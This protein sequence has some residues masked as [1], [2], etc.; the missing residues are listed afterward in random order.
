MFLYNTTFRIKNLYLIHNLLH[1]RKNES[2]RNYCNCSL[3]TKSLGS[4]QI[5][6]YLIQGYDFQCGSHIIVQKMQRKLCLDCFWHF[7]L[8]N[9]VLI[10]FTQNLL[11]YRAICNIFLQFNVA[12]WGSNI[13]IHWYWL[14]LLLLVGYGV[15][16]EFLS[17]STV[18]CHSTNQCSKDEWHS[19]RD[20]CSDDIAGGTWGA[21]Y[22]SVTCRRDQ[23]TV[24]VPLH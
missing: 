6:V 14:L 18:V 11:L 2:H 22:I 24:I 4:C 12:R 3:Q 8:A 23:E 20:N 16:F 1:F 13:F 10:S 15:A 19:T 7:E 5:P 21:C 17:H 9:S